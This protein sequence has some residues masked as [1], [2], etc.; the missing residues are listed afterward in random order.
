MTPDV[1]Y[2]ALEK[3]F[4]NFDDVMA[5][6]RDPVERKRITDRAYDDLIASGRWSYRA[7]IEDF[8]RHVGPAAGLG[9]TLTRDDHRAIEQRLRRSATLGRLTA[10]PRWLLRQIRFPGRPL[11]VRVYRRLRNRG[12]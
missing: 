2:L 4:S 5:R 3:D 12:E 6:F 9:H 10:R 7:A 11:A 1:H 8:D